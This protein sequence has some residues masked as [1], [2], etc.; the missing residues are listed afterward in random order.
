MVNPALIAKA[1]VM[2]LSN[3]KLRKGV[4]WLV[5]IILSPFILII[6]ILCVLL[7][8]GAENNKS[9][10]DAS[11]NGGTALENVSEEYTAGIKKMSSNFDTLDGIISNVNKQIENGQSLDS[12]RVKAIFMLCISLM[13]VLITLNMLTAL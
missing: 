10:V 1:V 7:S 2:T 11:F 9:A 13:I 3:K 4:G 12:V 5:A 6:V 8:G